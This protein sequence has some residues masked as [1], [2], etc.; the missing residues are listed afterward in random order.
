[1]KLSVTALACW[2]GFTWLGLPGFIFGAAV[3]VFSGFAVMAWRL[4]AG[5]LPV[6]R[7][8]VT[9]SAVGIAASAAIILAPAPLAESLGV[10]FLYVQLAL[11]L[12]VGPPALAW[13]VA[14]LRR[15][16]RR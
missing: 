3:G 8:T 10:E 4:E 14:R 13:V 15:E 2:G 9:A 5:A 7:Q 12:L 11:A 16:V 6:L 1:V